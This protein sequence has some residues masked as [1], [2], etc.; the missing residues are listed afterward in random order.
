ML[1][2]L[3]AP[4]ATATTDV[5]LGGQTFGNETGTGELKGRLRSVRL[6]ADRRGRYLVRLPA[7]SAAMLTF[8]PVA[9]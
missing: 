9:G 7:A 2:R 6:K 1:E 4:G 3:R 5:T 8:L